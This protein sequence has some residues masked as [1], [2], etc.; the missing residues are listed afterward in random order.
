MSGLS[1]SSA[2]RDSTTATLRPTFFWV[3]FA[4]PSRT[5]TP[6]MSIGG[7]FSLNTSNSIWPMAP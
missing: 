7:F 3:A 4:R 5:S 6:T 2:F 1:L